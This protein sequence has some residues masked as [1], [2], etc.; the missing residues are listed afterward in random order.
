MF[1]N[2]I[3]SLTELENLG[4][5]RNKRSSRIFFLQIL[6]KMQWLNTWNIW[7]SSGMISFL[8][9]T[10]ISNFNQ[11]VILIPRNWRD[12]TITLWILGNSGEHKENGC[13]YHTFT[14][15]STCSTLVRGYFVATWVRN[16]AEEKPLRNHHWNTEK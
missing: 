8:S 6:H 9:F 3:K 15:V 4:L 10:I 12:V 13:S 1:E 16:V 14:Y 7:R 2:H 11:N 5:S